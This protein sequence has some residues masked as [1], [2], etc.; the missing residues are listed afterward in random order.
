MP[1]VA[2]QQVVLRDRVS[3][4]TEE[5]LSAVDEFIDE[6]YEK[7][8]NLRRLPWLAKRVNSA[9]SVFDLEREYVEE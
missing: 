6:I 3:S 5:E 2:F 9:Q 7:R 8:A 1:W 4:L